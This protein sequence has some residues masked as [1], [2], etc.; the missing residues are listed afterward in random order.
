MTGISLDDFALEN[1]S[2]LDLRNKFGQPSGWR[3]TFAG[4]G[5][6]ATVAADERLSK[7]QLALQEEQEKARVN[8][9]KWK[10]TGDSVDDVRD[11]NIDYIVARLLRWSDGMTADGAPFPCTPENAKKILLNPALGVYEQVNSYLLDEKSFT[12]RSARI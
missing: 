5:H 2:D 3:W 11:R 12:P 4:P 9:R 1:E 10:G 7:R 8:G 6:S